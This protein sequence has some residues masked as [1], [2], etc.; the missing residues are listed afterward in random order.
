MP[1]TSMGV[2]LVV[3]K[4]GG[5]LNTSMGQLVVAAAVADDVLALVILS[6]LKAPIHNHPLDFVWPVISAFGFAIVISYLAI[7][8]I[9]GFIQEY[10]VK[11]ACTPTSV[12]SCFTIK[13]P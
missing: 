6:E 9:P 2:A 8:I 10:I 7:Y 5:A 1:P 12:R 13:A 3:L 4:S 11:R